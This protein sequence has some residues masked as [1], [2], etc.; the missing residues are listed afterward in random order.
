[1]SENLL[2]CATC[3]HP[4]IEHNEIAGMPERGHC[5]VP[6]CDCGAYQATE[7][8]TEARFTAIARAT[9][10]GGNYGTHLMAPGGDGTV[11][12]CP[13]EML[14]DMKQAVVEQFRSSFDGEE[15]THVAIVVLPFLASNDLVAPGG[16]AG[17]G[18]SISP[19]ATDEEV[20]E[21]IETA[22]QAFGSLPEESIRAKD[23]LG[24]LLW[25]LSKPL[26]VLA[27]RGEYEDKERLGHLAGELHDIGTVE[28]YELAR[29]IREGHFDH[30]EQG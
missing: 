9:D 24:M 27:V 18:I 7:M 1:M 19:E 10:A 30:G 23:R 2:P 29:Q 28:C 25:P 13:P 3:K 21:M 26:A 14:E 8:E 20:E 5:K 11:D 15:P 6:S 22:V 17:A 16:A 12:D 4:K